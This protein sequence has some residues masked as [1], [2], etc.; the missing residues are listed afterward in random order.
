MLIQAS[1]VEAVTATSIPRTQT[2]P[3]SPDFPKYTHH[4]DCVHSHRRHHHGNYYAHTHQH[5]GGDVEHGHSA[6]YWREQECLHEERMSFLSF[7]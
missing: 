3:V 2:R 4:G 6:K 1:V 5:P 7:F